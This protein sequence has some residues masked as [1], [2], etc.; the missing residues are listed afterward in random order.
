MC[1]IKL[2]H[3]CIYS[4][5]GAKFRR[6]TLHSCCELSKMLSDHMRDY[7]LMVGQLLRIGLL[8]HEDDRDDDDELK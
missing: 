4:S 7:G 8:V 1:E 3:S 2:A 6:E 5:L